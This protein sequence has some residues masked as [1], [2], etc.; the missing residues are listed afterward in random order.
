VLLGP[1]AL[2]HV[3]VTVRLDTPGGAMTLT[4]WVAVPPCVTGVASGS[5]TVTVTDALPLRLLASVAVV[6]IVNAPALA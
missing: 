2:T 3:Y 4:V 1:F 5:V 6:V